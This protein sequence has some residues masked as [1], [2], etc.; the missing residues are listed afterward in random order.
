MKNLGILFACVC[1]LGSLAYGNPVFEQGF[2]LYSC[3]PVTKPT[4]KSSLAAFR[5]YNWVGDESRGLIQWD[6]FT[7]TPGGRK[8]M[9]IIGPAKFR[10]EKRFDGTH[11]RP[12]LTV[13]SQWGGMPENR[14]TFARK[15]GWTEN[16]IV[17]LAEGPVEFSCYGGF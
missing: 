6:L 10:M 8:V 9:A 5:I 4:S 14:W 11:H 13:E 7:G 3:V 15:L 17:N 1:S 16:V 2:Q 12:E